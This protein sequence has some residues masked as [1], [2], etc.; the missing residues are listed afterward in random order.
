LFFSG[1]R[2]AQEAGAIRIN[3]TPRPLSMQQGGDLG[4]R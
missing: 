2:L 1:L 3:L 4:V